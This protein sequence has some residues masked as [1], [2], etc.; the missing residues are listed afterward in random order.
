MR[1]YHVLKRGNRYHYVCRIPGDLSHFFPVATIYRSLKTSDRKVARLLA[2]TLEHT[3][4]GVFMKLR[5]GHLDDNAI[6]L[7]LTS[8]LGAQLEVLEARLMH[9]AVSTEDNPA[10]SD[11]RRLKI[12]NDFAPLG[13]KIDCIS[14]LDP[15]QIGAYFSSLEPEQIM[16]YFSSFDQEQIVAYFSSLDPEQ[17]EAY[18]SSFDPEQIEAFF[19][20]S[21]PEQIGA[22]FSS[23][24]PEQIVTGFLSLGSEQLGVNTAK[25]IE[26]LRTEIK[27][28]VYHNEK[29]AKKLAEECGFRLHNDD[30]RTLQLRLLN[31]EMRLA[32]AEQAARDSDLSVLEDLREFLNR[33]KAAIKPRFYLD[34]AATDYLKR[35]DDPKCTAKLNSI[36]AVKREVAFILKTLGK[37]AKLAEFNSAAAVNKLSNALD[38]KTKSTGEPLAK[39]YKIEFLKRLSSIVQN[40]IDKNEL[41]VK[42]YA[43]THD[44]TDTSKDRDSYN[45]NDI[46]KLED[47]LCTVPILF[48]RKPRPRNDRF[49]IALA[50][51]LQGFRK[52]ALVDLKEKNLCID[53]ATKIEC[54][55]LR[56]GADHTGKVRILSPIHPLLIKVGFLKWLT[57]TRTG[58]PERKVFEDNSLGF[59]QWWNGT[60]ET[61]SWNRINITQNPKATFHSLRHYFCM[62]ADELEIGDKLKDEM[63]GHAERYVGKD[64]RQKHYL[65][66]TRP[67]RMREVQNMS[68]KKGK[69]LMCD[70]D[71]NRLQLRAKELFDLK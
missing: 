31:M 33:E 23:L 13:E 15:K 34:D 49:W 60:N 71:W 1:S 17:I 62:W 6:K 2:A 36:R 53:P 26:Q 57:K 51:F 9:R 30:K 54:F 68:M 43:V 48:G 58:N 64:V 52:S 41:N 44:A 37:S 45:T 63:S 21:D 69:I 7:L 70:I 42:N 28:K 27:S 32:K 8:Y 39:N 66:R 11:R 3:T 47:A 14:S 5:S 40:V 46:K 50:A 19:S 55:D 25:R 35:Y 4:Q 18:F 22:D 56:P 29:E 38:K 67:K 12:I 24:D 10:K 16:A 61:N 65:E 59:G 20:S